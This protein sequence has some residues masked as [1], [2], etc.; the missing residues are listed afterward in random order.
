V[1]RLALAVFVGLLIASPARA[2]S[3]TAE[4]LQQA[5]GLYENLDIDR[6]LVILQ[7]II[8]P[9]SPFL[10]TEEQRVAAFKY[11]G[12]ALALQQGRDKRDSAITFFRASIERD[13]FTDLDPQTFSPS[14]VQVFREAGLATF[15]VGLRPVAVDTIDPRTARFR[16]RGLTTHAAHIR[17]ELR[18]G[19]VSRGVIYDGE[20]NG[21]REFEWDGLLSEGRLAPPGRYEL[22]LIGES[23]RITV[24]TPVQD[25][26]HVYLELEWL[27]EPLE[28]TLAQ[29]G[30]AD[31]LPEQYQASA[32]TSD[33][34][35]GAAVAA[36]ALLTQ[37]VLSSSQLG[38]NR[39]AM[40]VVASGGAI[41]GVGAF[42][43]RQS[44]RA[45]PQNMAENQRRRLQREQ[46]N[47]AI[48]QRN[49]AK[50]RETRMAIAPA[51]GAGR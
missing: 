10:V 45:I 28:D 4:M 5:I 37:G 16:F 7:R 21:V 38:G 19:G 35:K 44:H 8:S 32:A 18:S 20:S 30:A 2:Q 22:A 13:P 50:L 3:N 24:P 23:R 25:S 14:Q 31:L 36:A 17:L 40:G 39:T 33:L 29:L 11:L 49:D 42:F 26:A 9:S 46:G 12:A 6:A 15:K 47:A 43:Y 1:R 51:A 41:A 27:H 48:N 34:L